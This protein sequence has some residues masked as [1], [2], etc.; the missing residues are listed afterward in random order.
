MNCQYGLVG[1][2]CAGLVALFGAGLYFTFMTFHPDPDRY[3]VRG[4]DV[5]HH[6]GAI[7]WRQ[8]AGAGIDFAYMKATE[9]GDFSDRRFAENWQAAKDAGVRRGAYHFFTFCR[10]GADQAAHFIATVPRDPDA[11]PPAVDLEF[12][13]NCPEASGR[14]DVEKELPAF[15]ERVEAHYGRKALLYATPEYYKAHMA[16]TE[17]ANPLWLRSLVFEP[18]YNH[19]PWTVWQYHNRGT[20]AGIAGPVDRNVFAGSVESFEAGW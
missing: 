10:P 20:V 17:I 3:P 16:G 8:V 18:D 15:L 9:G 7:D 5:S 4:I 13:G 2:A 11:L 12:G 1:A 6:Q 19:H 14:L